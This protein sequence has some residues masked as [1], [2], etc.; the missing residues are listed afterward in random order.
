MKKEE[1]KKKLHYFFSFFIGL[2][3]EE[4]HQCLN[5]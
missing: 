5:S 4:F 3:F 2:H 1:K